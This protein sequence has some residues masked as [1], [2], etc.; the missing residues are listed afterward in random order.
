M[1]AAVLV[2]HN[3]ADV[4]A[5]TLNSIEQQ[6]KQ[7]DL[8]IAVDDSSTDDTKLILQKHGFTVVDSSSTSR[9]TTTRIAHNFVQGVKAA[10][11]LGATVMVL[12]DHD[13][14]WYPDRIQHQVELLGLNPTTAFLASD[15]TVTDTTTLRSTFPVPADFNDWDPKAQWRYVAKHSIATG[16][17]SA[18]V[19]ANLS[20]LDVPDGWLHDRWWSLRAVREHSMRIDPTPVITY[21]ISNSQ[22]VGLSTRGQ[23]SLLL[24]CGYALIDLPR[25]SK[26]IWDVGIL[27]LTSK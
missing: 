23:G 18:I 1:I 17:A 10:H 20:T 12:G 7:P 16:G 19:P 21:R 9:E 5:E 13:D 24:Q 6:S 14:I 27:L 26:R 11:E 25:T 4:I 22:Q 2:T 8:R 15:G 3:S